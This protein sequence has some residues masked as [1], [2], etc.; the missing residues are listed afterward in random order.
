MRI[1]F[2]VPYP[3][4]H[5]PSQRFR[6]EQYFGLLKSQ[7][8]QFSVCPFWT[9]KS[10]TILYKPG[11]FIKKV[12]FFLK[13]LWSRT[14]TLFS[15]SH[16]DFVFIH[17]ECAPLG[18]PVFEFIISKVLKKKVIY[19][20]DDAI[21][22]EN[23]S[24]EN[25]IASILKWHKKVASICR[26]S[27]TISCGNAFLGAYASSFHSIVV[28]NPTT[29]DT[30]TLHNPIGMKVIKKEKLVIGWTG[31]HSTLPY[32]AM[33]FPVFETLQKKFPNQFS[34]LVIAD[35]NPNFALDYVEFVAW[36]KEMEIADLMRIDIGV[37]PLTD[38]DWAR[39]KC[40]F[41]ALQY[42]ALEIP[43]LLSPVGV[44]T[45]I[46]KH[47]V[48]GFHCAHQQEWVDHL[49]N[50]MVN[51]D[52]RKKMGEAGRQSVISHYSIS[53]NSSNFLGLFS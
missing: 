15:L 13:G 36:N 10:W 6:F 28:I 41:K 25:K 14:T 34:L 29:I 33:L 11:H 19:D 47:G 32:L 17:R 37:M 39:G 48:S 27:Y 50:L 45:S 8:I 35:R 40:G 3:E 42:M 23:T 51:S 12:F 30:Q 18:P 2:L 43:T 5:A 53:S 38:D 1:I 21:W 22:L 46:V 24:E 7:G 20:F 31:T 52:L 16:F 9:E 26:W 44:N 49:E 4:G